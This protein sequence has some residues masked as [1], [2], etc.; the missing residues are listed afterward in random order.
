MNLSLLD[1]KQ[2]F[3]DLLSGQISREEAE[4]WA[5]SCLEAVE[6]TGVVVS[7]EDE[8]LFWEAIIYLSAVAMRL[9]PVE[10]MHDDE[11]ISVEYYSLCD[12]THGAGVR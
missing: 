8:E 5:V 7:L 1:V 2:V 12:R 3:V 4:R 6:K 9:S 10:Y 11:D